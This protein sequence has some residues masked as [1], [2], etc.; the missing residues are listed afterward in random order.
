MY[1]VRVI[2]RMQDST[3]RYNVPR[4]TFRRGGG[5]GVVKAVTIHLP[6]E[7]LSKVDALVNAGLYM[8]RAEAIRLILTRAVEEESMLLERMGII[9]TEGPGPVIKAP[10][11]AGEA[12]HTTI[13][14]RVPITLL[15]LMKIAAR[16]MGLR[17][18]SELV[19]ISVIDFILKRYRRGE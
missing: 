16:R 14:F 13:A 19:R 17:S 3:N 6:E 12:K 1:N 8:N 5:G 18:R 2:S 10:E 15:H 7:T 4:H 9:S 11:E